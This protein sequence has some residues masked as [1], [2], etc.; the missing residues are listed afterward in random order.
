MSTDACRSQ[1]FWGSM[2]A[3]A[4]AGPR[5]IPQRQLNSKNLAEAIRYC[6]TPEASTAARTLAEKMR[7]EDGVR[8]AVNHFHANL[9]L[10]AMQCD[11]LKNK[12]AAWF[13]KKGKV[14]MKLSK[15]AAETLV[16]NSLVTSDRLH[17]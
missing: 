10:E 3:A 9:P 14:H 15:L 13:F 6:L 11:I 1:P 12:A 7:A 8:N 16:E 5:P 2:V 17:R 4:G